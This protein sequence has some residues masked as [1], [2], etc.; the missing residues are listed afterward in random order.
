MAHPR[1]SG[2]PRH[3]GARRHRDS[4]K[5]LTLSLASTRRAGPLRGRQVGWQQ[6]GDGARR[7]GMDGQAW[8]GRTAHPPTCRSAVHIPR[9]WQ[10]RGTGWQVHRARR[11]TA[12]LPPPPLAPQARRMRCASTRKLPLRSRRTSW[13]W[14]LGG[15]CTSWREG[16]GRPHD[17]R[18]GPTAWHS[19]NRCYRWPSPA[20][21]AGA[22]P[23]RQQGRPWGASGQKVWELW[24]HCWDAGL[25]VQSVSAT[26][27]KITCCLI[28]E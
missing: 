18:A 19:C 9:H 8:T 20:A 26:K 17:D 4:S 27:R 13:R 24:L 10:R 5:P 1:G 2:T 22:A 7:A 23:L 3:A 25:L 28:S 12:P 16:W 11:P 6:L 14:R 21:P 15:W